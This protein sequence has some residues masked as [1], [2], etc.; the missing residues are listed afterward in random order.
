[1]K[2]TV[3]IEGLSELEAALQELPR[4]T[5][6]NVLKRAIV[7]PAT[8]FAEKAR[9]RATKRT[10]DLKRGIVVGKPRVI[11]AGKAAFAEAMRRG[12]SRAEAGAA[13]REANR[14]SGG[15]GRHA[16]VA[17]GPT[18]S[19]YYGQF[20]EFGTARIAARPFM[21]PTWDAMQFQMAEDIKM[22]LADEIERARARLARKAARL[23]SKI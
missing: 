2:T 14:E 20:Q 15:A 17:V 5:G 21:R 16:V 3:K 10:G 1:M 13:S 22:T 4:A 12:A 9:E 19:A 18:R 11:S 6:G 7:K 23:A 8:A